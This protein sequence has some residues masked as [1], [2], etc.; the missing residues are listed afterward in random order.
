MQDPKL[1]KWWSVAADFRRHGDDR[2][3]LA[4]HFSFSALEY[5]GTGNEVTATVRLADAPS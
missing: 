3:L 5:R 2:I 1:A 4:R